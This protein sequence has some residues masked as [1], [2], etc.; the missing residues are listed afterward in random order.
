MG[1]RKVKKKENFICIE[2]LNQIEQDLFVLS[3][4]EQNA[5]CCICPERHNACY[6]KLF[7]SAS[8]LV[9]HSVT[10]HCFN[11]SALYLHFCYKV[12][13]RICTGRRNRNNK[14]RTTSSLGKFMPTIQILLTHNAALA[15][16]GGAALIWK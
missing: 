7:S 6:N 8:R 14:S 16:D 15:P 10:A 12:E 1:R 3:F 13:L 5:I 2:W 4:S 11:L 9:S